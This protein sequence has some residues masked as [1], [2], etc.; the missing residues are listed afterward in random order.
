MLSFIDYIL[1]FECIR[2]GCIM[3]ELTK[4]EKEILKRI[5]LNGYK[6]DYE[7]SEKDR[8]AADSTVYNALRKFE[9]L[10]LIEV[11]HEEP[12]SKIPDKIKKRYYGLTFR[13]LIMALKIEGVKLHLVKNKEELLMLW[14]Q[15]ISR[16]DSVLKVSETLFK[17]KETDTQKQLKA[18]IIEHLQKYPEE[19]EEFLKHYDLDYSDDFLIFTEWVNNV[20]YREL[21]Y[22]FTNRAERRILMK[23][24]DKL[25]ESFRAAFLVSQL[26]NVRTQFPKESV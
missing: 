17:L 2:S 10:G 13:G 19:V 4:T 8:V 22:T 15:T 1:D 6:T 24:Y 9:K 12:F 3:I 5:A 21:G 18:T 16:I 25:P 11:K 20:V 23:V 26:W 7:L 14:I